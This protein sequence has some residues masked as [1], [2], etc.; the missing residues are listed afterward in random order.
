MA[1]ADGVEITLTDGRT[2]ID[3]MSSWWAAL[4]GYNNPRLNE[5]VTGQLAKMS[6]IMFGGLTHESAVKLEQ[7]LSLGTRLK[8]SNSCG[9]ERVLELGCGSGDL[10]LRLQRKFGIRHRIVNDLNSAALRQVE[11]ELGQSHY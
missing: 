4:H 8:V 6:H 9:F 3:G 7:L 5:A 1:R 2:L 10:T 11:A